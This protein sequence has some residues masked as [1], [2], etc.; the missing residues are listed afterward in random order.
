MV[1]KSTLRN[2]FDTGQGMHGH[3]AG[4]FEMGAAHG[5]QTRAAGFWISFPRFGE[6]PRKKQWLVPRNFS[7]IAEF[8]MSE[9]FHKELR[10]VL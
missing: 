3:R 8:F 6:P 1:P 10:S 9:D 5:D 4:P 7:E 2:V